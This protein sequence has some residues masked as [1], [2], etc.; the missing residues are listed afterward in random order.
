[1]SV[2]ASGLAGAWQRALDAERQAA[3]GYALAG[4]QLGPDTG[5]RLAGTCQSAH[6]ALCDAAAAAITA[7]G[8]APDPPPADYPSL[9]PVRTARSARQLA[10]RLENDAASAWRYLYAVAAGTTGAQAAAAR[11]AA[12]AALTASALRAT[13]WRLL[14]TPGAATVAFPG[15]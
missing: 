6:E 3:F 4:P 2:Q 8:G 7:A 12:Q 14:V 13:R 1:M 9:Y 10:I 5:S 11:P 15:I